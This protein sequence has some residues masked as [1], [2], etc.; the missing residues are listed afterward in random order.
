MKLKGRPLWRTV[1]GGA[2][3]YVKKLTAAYNDRVR[4]GAGAVSVRRDGAGVWVRDVAGLVERH[5]Q[6]VIAAHA[7]QA[8]AM[9][10]AASDQERGLLGACRYTKNR[11]ILHTDRALM[12][13]REP[14]WASWNYVGD[15]REGGCVVSYWM[16]KLQNLRC[17]EQLFLTLNP[18]TMPRDETILHETEYEHPLFDAPALRAQEQLW[19]LQGVRNTWFC[20]AYFGAGFHEDALQAGLAVAEQLAGMRRPWKVEDESGRIHLAAH[21]PMANAA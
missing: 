13:R 17:E 5:D 3:A 16:N 11:A 1:T 9:L 20:G 14:L 18:Q 15:N 8:L 4:L 10:D 12:P 2:R 6:V 19:S 21:E 7:D